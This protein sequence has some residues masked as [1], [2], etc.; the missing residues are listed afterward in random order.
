MRKLKFVFALLSGLFVFQQGFSLLVSDSTISIIVTYEDSA[1]VELAWKTPQGA[2]S[3]KIVHETLAGSITYMI[4]NFTQDSTQIP[5]WNPAQPWDR[6]SIYFD[7]IQGDTAYNYT[8]IE[9]AT[10]GGVV[11]IHEEVFY[12]PVVLGC[13]NQVEEAFA[14]METCVAAELS[15]IKN[16][17]DNYLIMNWIDPYDP[18]EFGNY[19]SNT[20]FNEFDSAAYTS[21]IASELLEMLE[22]GKSG[23]WD[24]E[25]FF[26]NG[27][28]GEAKPFIPKQY[29]CAPNPFTNKL[30]IKP[31]T[32]GE[33]S[34][35]PV[36]VRDNMGRIIYQAHINN[37]GLTIPT[38]SWASG[39]YI[40][41]VGSGIHTQTFKTM[42]Y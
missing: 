9:S 21:T 39:M 26:N 17:S 36:I 31:L 10:Y 11:I 38:Q 33:R 29:S 2:Q 28:K 35:A 15:I 16:I 7:L 27:R 12:Q 18:F 30:L 41:Q 14:F 20:G 8:Q 37:E 4:P 19:F 34:S 25:E 13:R 5:A 3:C 22:Q 23:V 1:V 24:C 6:F 42:K 32:Q 40:V